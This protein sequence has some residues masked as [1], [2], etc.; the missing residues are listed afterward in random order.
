M[1]TKLAGIARRMGKLLLIE[2]VVPGGSLIVLAI[3]IAGAS[4]APA[5]KRLTAFLPT[6]LL[7]A[8]GGRRWRP[9]GDDLVGHYALERIA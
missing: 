9:K 4:D 3:L 1:A 5:V 8:L 2:L 7:R 6:G